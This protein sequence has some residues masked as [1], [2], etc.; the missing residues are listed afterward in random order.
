MS[1]SVW[2]NTT[3]EWCVEFLKYLAQTLGTTYEALNVW[4]FVVILP[5]VLLI[6]LIINLYF[7]LKSTGQGCVA[8]EET[9]A[10]YEIMHLER[11]MENYKDN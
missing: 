2:V 9:I 11:R 4:L 10:D 3:F 7:V 1:N 8:P 6:S 5:V